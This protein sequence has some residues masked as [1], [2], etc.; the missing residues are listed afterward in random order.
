[1]NYSLHQLH[2]FQKVV[3]NKSITKASEQLNMTQP[4]VSIQLKNL[5]Q[6]FE[7]P[8]T[9]VIG[10]QLY[11]TD[12]GMDIYNIA[13]RIL[14]DVERIDARR[15]AFKGLLQ[16]RLRIASV[17][18]GKY[19]LPYYLND[20]LDAHPGVTL[21]LDVTNKQEVIDAL[22]NNQVD[23]AFL[24]VPPDQMQLES[25][26]LMP[27][28]LLLTGPVDH[29][30]AQQ[31]RLSQKWW[32]ELPLIYREPGSGTRFQMQNYFDDKQVHPVIRSQLKSNEAVKQAL[33]AGLGFSIISLV[34][35]K[36]E[37]TLKQL[38]IINVPDLPLKSNWQ[39]VWRK[40]KMLTPVAE[41]FLD[42]LEDEHERIYNEHFSWQEEYLDQ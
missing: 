31:K 1:M 21:D 11:I 40:Q 14:E 3:E 39:L 20:F 13:C 35:L 37:L 23:F 6:Q 4:A 25:K 19:V 18:T 28:Y 9:E 29:P 17:S 24:T 42:F 15:K 36:N 38:K 7:I 8:L 30:F 12:F 34:S 33:L 22:Q 41:A 5:Q 10:R 2:V 32:N 16:G 26:I 27:N